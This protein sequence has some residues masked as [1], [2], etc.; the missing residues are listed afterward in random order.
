MLSKQIESLRRQKGWSQAELARRLHL[1][2]STLG[3]YEQERREPSID[4]IVAIA[5]EFGVSTDYLITGKHST[6]TESEICTPY[7]CSAGVFTMLRNLSR[8][9]L[10]VLLVSN[11][12]TH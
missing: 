8:E 3:M 12:M 1:S 6:M 7:G 4:T 10:I 11:L 9:E 2:P 5:E